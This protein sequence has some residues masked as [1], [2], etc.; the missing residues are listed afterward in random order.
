MNPVGKALWFIESHF[1]EELTLD[2]IA[3]IAGV[4]RF[5]MT[6][7]FG[8]ATGHSIMR[9]VRGRRLSEAARSLASGA[10]DILSVALDA[11]YASHEAFTRAF[12]DQFGLT[13]E[14]IRSQGRLSQISLLEPLRME[15]ITKPIIEPTRFEQG[16]VL[17]I[18]GVGERYTCESSAAIPSQWQRFVPH[19]GTVPR[20]VDGT[21]YGVRCNSDDDGSFDYICGVEVAGFSVPSDW[22]RLRIAPQRYVV[23]THRDHISTIRTTWS[24]IWNIWLPESGYEVVDAPDFERYGQEFDG[25]TGMGGCEIWI[26]VRSRT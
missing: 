12:N 19:I 14:T 8:E 13:P 20:Q 17:L 18:A 21:A 24:T 22:A 6:R 10:P 15:Q 3:G 23:F 9:Y 16:R 26:P 25:R 11:G 2:E 7:A 4:S 5:Y 1:R